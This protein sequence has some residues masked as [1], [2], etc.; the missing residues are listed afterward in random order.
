MKEII[1]RS[2]FKNKEEIIRGEKGKRRVGNR[3]DS[4]KNSI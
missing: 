2:F 3:S 1:W 4:Y